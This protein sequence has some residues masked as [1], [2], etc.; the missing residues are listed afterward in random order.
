MKKIKACH[1]ST[2]HSIRDIRIFYKECQTLAANGYD[3]TYISQGIH[4]EMIDGVRRLG[5]GKLANKN[6]LVRM[7]FGCRQLVKIAIAENADIYHIH[8]SELLRFAGL[9]KKAGKIVIYDSHEHL[10]M[11][12]MEKEWIPRIFRSLIA[13][14]VGNIELRKVRFIDLIIVVADKTFHRFENKGIE[15]IKL[16]NFPIFSEFKD[17]VIDYNVKKNH[18]KICYAGAVWLERGL[19]TMC[20]AAAGTENCTLEIAGRIDHASPHEYIAGIGDNIIYSG[21]LSRGDV[22]KLYE[23][24]I[25]GLCLFKPYPNNMIDP[26]TKIFEYM[27]AGIPVIG[28]AFE[29]ISDVVEKYECGLC[30]NP[31]DINEISNAIQFLLDNPEEAKRMGINGRKAVKEKMNWEVHSRIFIDAYGKLVEKKNG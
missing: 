29:S 4:D 1:I 5:T 25:A 23:E 19:D 20:R 16:E 7:T 8:D 24:S 21:Y 2:V 13:K 12:I 31:L 10:P 27:A 17:I 26:P 30:V 11:Q 9:F 3:V 18:R 15:L 22:V 6:K 14:F 28:S